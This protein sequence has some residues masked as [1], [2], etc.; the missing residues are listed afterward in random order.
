M[1]DEGVYTD[2]LMRYAGSPDGI[3]KEE[4]E[5]F[6]GYL[7]KQ[8]AFANW[9]NIDIIVMEETLKQKEI[10]E[11]IGQTED[12]LSTQQDIYPNWDQV[13]LVSKGLMTL[14]RDGFLVKQSRS[15]TNNSSYE[16][17]EAGASKNKFLN[18]LQPKKEE[19]Q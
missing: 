19:Q 8:L 7:N 11:M 9:S 6:W 13:F 18:M 2:N 17:K 15:T 4:N 3:P 16:M 14:G 1:E 5:K 10:T 12:E